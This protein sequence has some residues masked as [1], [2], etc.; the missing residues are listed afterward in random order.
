MA[1]DVA[2]FRDPETLPWRDPVH[3]VCP[4][5]HGRAT[6]HTTGHNSARLLCPNCVLTREWRGDRLHVLVKGHPVVLRKDH[7][8]WL[9]PGTGQYQR[10]F[11]AEEA[12][13]PRFGVPLWLRLECCGGH[14]LW[15]NNE[16][17]LDYL[18]SYVGAT[19]RERPDGPARLSWY[20]LSWMKQAKHRDEV[21]RSLARL[22]A[23]LNSR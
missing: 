2:R 22:R 1:E 21:L 4:A 18:E 20:L 7:G 19:L 13:D 16:A 6:V 15:A 14:L 12:S 23:S 11:D 8:A 5:C 17:H 10:H 9:N 3:V